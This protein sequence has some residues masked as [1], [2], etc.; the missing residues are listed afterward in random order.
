MY[1]KH[2]QNLVDALNKENINHELKQQ[3]IDA[4]KYYDLSLEISAML[5]KKPQEDKK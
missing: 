3:L 2:L 1:M 5:E 4:L